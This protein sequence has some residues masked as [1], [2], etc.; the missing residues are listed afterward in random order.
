MRSRGTGALPAR[1][2]AARRRFERW[3]R[4][5]EGRSRIPD[6]LWNSAVKLS[7][8]Y[9]IH[10]TAKTLRLNPDSLK[11]HVASADGNGSPRQEATATFVE[12]VP[13]G[14][15]C[16]PECIVELED[17]RGAKM[18]IQLEGNQSPDVVTAVSRVLFSAET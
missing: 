1:L 8:T 11:K 3:R 7:A 5:R 9:G 12:L 14:P 18:R 13:S 16:S 17:P 2:E 6:P 10:R 4:T 15:S